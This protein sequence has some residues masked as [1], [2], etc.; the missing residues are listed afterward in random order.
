MD[1]TL[2]MQDIAQ[3]ADKAGNI[4]QGLDRK[5]KENHK[6]YIDPTL[7]DQKDT[8]TA[9]GQ[10]DYLCQQAQQQL[11][12]AIAEKRSQIN[13]RY[14]GDVT[15]DQLANVNQL[16]NYNDLSKDELQGY[17]DKYKDNLPLLK[18]FEAVVKAKGWRIDG[19]TYDNEIEFLKRFKASMQ[20][21]VDGMKNGSPKGLPLETKIAANMVADRV[22]DWETKTNNPTYTL[23]RM[24]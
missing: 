24:H 2:T 17:L 12:K 16:A 13:G 1:Y 20:T 3:L 8:Q 21:I 4:Y 22:K 7:Q 11:D 23:Q 9:A 19:L 10:I 14:H 15:A 18:A 6:T 5:I